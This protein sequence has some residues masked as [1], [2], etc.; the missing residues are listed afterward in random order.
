MKVEFRNDIP[1]LNIC[2][3]KVAMGNADKKLKSIA[4]HIAPSVDEDGVAH[5]VEKFI[6]S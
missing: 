2:G 1:L 4:H 6:L 3:L 5:V